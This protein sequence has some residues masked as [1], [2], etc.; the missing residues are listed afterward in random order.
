MTSPDP[1]LALLAE[2]RDLLVE[3]RDQGKPRSIGVMPSAMPV[4]RPA[5]PDRQDRHDT[6]G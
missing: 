2:I 3:I 4:V 6:I 5:K 1:Q